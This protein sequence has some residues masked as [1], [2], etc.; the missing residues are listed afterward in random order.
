M[1]MLEFRDDDQG[2]LSWLA[3]HPDGYVINILGSYK[4]A[5]TARLHIAGCWTISGENPH[6]GPWTGTYVKVC[7]DELDE[8]D[9]WAHAHVAVPV[10]RCGVCHPAAPSLAHAREDTPASAPTLRGAA[11]ANLVEG[12]TEVRGPA[13]EHPVVEAWADD[14]IH[15]DHPPACQKLLCAEIRTRVSQL[16]PAPDQVLNATF[17]GAK[18]AGADVENLLLY[19]IGSFGQTGRFG[20]RF[21]HAPRVPTAP[22]G[23][24]YAY[25]YRYELAPRV[26]GLVGWREARWL[27]SWD[28][29]DLG[30]FAGE[31]KLAQVCLALARAEVNVADEVR[32]VDV[33]FAVRV[34]IRPPHGPRPV[35]G[36]L[37][38]SV[39][40]G[41]ICAFEAHTDRSTLEEPAARIAATVKADQAEIE[42]LLLDPS[43]AVL[44]S[45][46]Q[47]V[48]TYGAGV[49]WDPADNLCVAGELLADEPVDSRWAIKGEIAELEPR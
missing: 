15:F 34:T 5:A 19:N 35:L 9:E 47:L 41:V 40:D 27:A 33:P 31:K 23:H 26:A 49:K 11:S 1:S 30:A 6:G 32:A 3:A 10:R 16:E 45:K 38:K 21:E 29:V 24:D 14:Y 13:A 2:Y 48:R 37:L 28:W 25:G 22:D 39:F 20:L 46:P 17:F 43:H 4:S 8:L 12:R 42:A 7:A 36:A 18:H 44:G